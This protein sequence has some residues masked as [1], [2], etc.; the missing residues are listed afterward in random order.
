MSS[1]PAP[2]R[3]GNPDR[4]RILPAPRRGETT[5]RT[6]ACARALRVVP[7]RVD[8]NRH[9]PTQPPPRIRRCN[10]PKNRTPHHINRDRSRAARRIRNCT[11]CTW[12]PPAP[13]D[14]VNH[15]YVRRAHVDQQHA[16]DARPPELIHVNR[17]DSCASVSFRRQPAAPSPPRSSTREVARRTSNS[18]TRQPRRR[19]AR[20]AGLRPVRA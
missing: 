9:G 10:A 2:L 1:G 8:R 3:E 20:R 17:A 7:K 6:L 16:G 18:P 15:D 14:R 11:P 19:W 12:R 5:R 4:P 13:S